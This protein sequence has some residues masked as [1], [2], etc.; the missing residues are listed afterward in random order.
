[1][2]YYRACF[3]FVSH[4]RASS[5]DFPIYR[6]FMFVFNNIQYNLISALTDMWIGLTT[7]GVKLFWESDLPTTV[8]NR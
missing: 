6:E 1:M 8:V 2:I 5:F 3:F 7:N 4:S